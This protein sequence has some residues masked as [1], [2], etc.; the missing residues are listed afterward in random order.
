MQVADP[1]TI[2]KRPENLFVAGFI[3]SPEMNFLS[4]RLSGG[5]APVFTFGDQKVRFGE[6]LASRLRFDETMD[7]RLGIRRQHLRVQ[8]GADETTISG[9]LNHVEFMG[10]EVFL[11]VDLGAERVI[12]II[13][14]AEF[15]QLGLLSD[16]IHMRPEPEA[17]HVFETSGGRNISLMPEFV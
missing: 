10:H 16:H 15:E 14:A 1:K 5:C 9:R 12:S 8:P 3:G 6:Q 11:Y 7:V 2:Y 13:D 17:V 4:G